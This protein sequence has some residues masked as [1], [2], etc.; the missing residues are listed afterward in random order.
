VADN[1]DQPDNVPYHHNITAKVLV[2][3]SIYMSQHIEISLLHHGPNIRNLRTQSLPDLL[4][5]H[6]SSHLPEQHF[7]LQPLRSTA[8]KRF[9]EVSWRLPVLL[10]FECLVARDATRAHEHLEEDVAEREG[11]RL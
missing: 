5:P 10:D 2:L 11:F 3:C 9:Y 8:F 6:Q 7:L 4:P 1:G